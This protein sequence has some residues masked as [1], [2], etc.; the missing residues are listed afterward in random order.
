MTTVLLA[1]MIVGGDAKLTGD[2][3]RVPAGGAGGC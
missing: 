1:G 3:I 2:I